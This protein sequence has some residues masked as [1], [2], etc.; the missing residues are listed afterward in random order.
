MDQ[1]LVLRARQ[2]D[3]DAFS[4]IASGTIGR[5]TAVARLILHN[6]DQAQDAVQDAL[7]DAWRG[8]HGLRD[9]DRLD[10]WLYR[11]LVRAC[12]THA[13]R[14]WTR[15][16]VELRMTSNHL[17]AAVNADQSVDTHDQL[18]RGLRRL[19]VDQRAVL[20]LTYYVDLPLAEAAGVLGIPLGTMKSRLNRAMDALRAVL[21]A[22]DRE[23]GRAMERMA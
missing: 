17:S 11:L 22:D 7:V 13:K 19:P 23:P 6:E 16:V 1:E 4:A 9:P 2:G 5:L 12:H 3:H 8:I 18:E 21:E 15:H 10:G 14:D 20:V